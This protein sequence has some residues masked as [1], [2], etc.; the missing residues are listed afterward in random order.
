[1]IGIADLYQLEV[2][3]LVVPIPR[4][5]RITFSIRSIV[6]GLIS[7]SLSWRSAGTGLRFVNAGNI[8]GSSIFNFFAHGYSIKNQIALSTGKSSGP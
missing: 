2:G 8:F 4:W 7:K 3:A 5:M 6:A 1:M